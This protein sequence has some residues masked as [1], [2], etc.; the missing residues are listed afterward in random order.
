MEKTEPLIAIDEGVAVVEKSFAVGPR[1]L[2][3]CGVD[4]EETIPSVCLVVL[5]RCSGVAEEDV[6]TEG[7]EI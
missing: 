1:Q 4:A 2:A 3:L 7:V 5:Y 6:A